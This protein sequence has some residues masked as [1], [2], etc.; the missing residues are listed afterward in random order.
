MVSLPQGF[1]GAG[2]SA[3]IKSS[4]KRDLALIINE[5]PQKY[6]TAIKTQ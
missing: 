1:K 2:V 4:G 5:G 3:G 6:G